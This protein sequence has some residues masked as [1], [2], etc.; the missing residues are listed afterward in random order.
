MKNKKTGWN[1]RNMFSLKITFNSEPAQSS[2]LWLFML[3]RFWSGPD[4]IR[5]QKSE[6]MKEAYAICF[7]LSLLSFNRI[8]HFPFPGLG[9]V[10]VSTNDWKKIRKVYLRNIYVWII[11]NYPCNAPPRWWKL[12]SWL[13]FSH[14]DPC[15]IEDGTIPIHA[16]SSDGKYGDTKWNSMLSTFQKICFGELILATKTFGD[17]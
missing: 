16:L 7:P 11:S 4:L 3:Q 5:T 1:R 15:G 17:T 2:A 9:N 13:S 8:V 6:T 12:T 14:S 10:K